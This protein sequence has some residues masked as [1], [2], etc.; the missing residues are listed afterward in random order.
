MNINFK[1]KE[2]LFDLRGQLHKYKIRQEMINYKYCDRVIVKELNPNTGN[3]YICGKFLEDNE[4]EM[5]SAGWVNIKFLDKEK[6]EDL[7]EEAM[8]SFLVYV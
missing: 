8:I 3:G 7:L 4:Y 1:E 6:I 5:N 2:D